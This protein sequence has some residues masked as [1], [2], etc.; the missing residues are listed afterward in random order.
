MEWSPQQARERFAAS[1]VARLATVDK[2][3]QPHL[4]PVVFAVYDGTVAIPVDGR[5]ETAYRLGWMLDIEANPR[6]SLLVDDHGED[7]ERSWWA[8]ADGEALVEHSGPAWEEAR[9]RL[10]ERYQRYRDEPPGEVMI[11]VAVHHWSGWSA[12]D[13]ARP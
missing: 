13:P 6:V 1:R 8:R 5:P 11:L 3:G 10:A 4:V 9:E 2:K 7:P 12:R